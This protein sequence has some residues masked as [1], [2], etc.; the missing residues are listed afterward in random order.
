MSD[1]AYEAMK[2]LVATKIING[3]GEKLLAPGDG[4]TR[5]EVATIIMRFTEMN[6]NDN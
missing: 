2:Y 6:K 4:A 5:A 1:W 3:K